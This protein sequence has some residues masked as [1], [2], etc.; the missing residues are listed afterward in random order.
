MNKKFLTAVLL[1]AP[2][3]QA[4]AQVST[5]ETDKEL[6]Q[7]NAAFVFTESQLGEDEDMTQNVIM[8]NSNN[9]VYTS[10]VGYLWSPVRFKFRA[11]SSQY[12]DIYMNGVQ[13]NN[14]ENGQFN[15]ST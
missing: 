2:A 1:T 12:S 9:N 5:P 14:V 7:D 4:F 11:Y 10:N 15:Y 8:M 6:K 3:I 13:V